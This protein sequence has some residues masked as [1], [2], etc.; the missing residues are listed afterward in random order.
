MEQSI[1]FRLSGVYASLGISNTTEDN[2][3]VKMPDLEPNRMPSASHAI[4]SNSEMIKIL[5]HETP[6]EVASFNISINLFQ[7][8]MALLGI[9]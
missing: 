7:I 9:K 5:C 8:I 3:H 6:I 2:S 1:R 4:K